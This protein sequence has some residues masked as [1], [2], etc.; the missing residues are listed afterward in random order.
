MF[1]LEIKKKKKKK[2]SKAD[3]MARWAKAP[4]AK[5]GDP[6]NT[7]L[8]VQ[9]SFD[10]HICAVFARKSVCVHAHAQT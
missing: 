8:K 1:G 3:D 10:F 2:K 7:R 6:E 9:L 4:A 5:L